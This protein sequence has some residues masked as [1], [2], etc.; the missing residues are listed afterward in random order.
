MSRG[1]FERQRV[2]AGLL[3]E[4]RKPLTQS[5]EHQ[6][7]R[8]PNPDL[9]IGRQAADE[10]GRDPII[11]SVKTRTVLRAELVADMP[12]DER[13]DGPGHVADAERRQREQQ[14]GGRVAAREEDLAEDESCRGPVDEEV[15][16]LQRAAAQLASAAFFGVFA[17]CGSCEPSGS[18]RTSA[19]SCSSYPGSRHHFALKAAKCCSI[20]WASGSIPVKRRNASAA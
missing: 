2:R 7:D 5:Q 8:R 13:P 4:S 3:A 12:E 19:I 17:P 10:E 16:V 18:Y 15:V 6:H 1:V 14:A 9:V 11:S 20:R